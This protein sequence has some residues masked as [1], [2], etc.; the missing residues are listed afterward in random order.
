M[1]SDNFAMTSN[2]VRDRMERDISQRMY[3]QKQG[4][5]KESAHFKPPFFSNDKEKRAHCFSFSFSVYP[6]PQSRVEYK[7]PLVFLFLHFA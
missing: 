7:L 4:K 5:K 3:S 6:C 1:H 2:L